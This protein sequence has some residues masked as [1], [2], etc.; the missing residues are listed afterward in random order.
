MGT[1]TVVPRVGR[2]CKLTTRD[3]MAIAWRAKRD[4]T[5]TRQAVQDNVT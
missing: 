5:V 1:P 2:P 4:P 3:E